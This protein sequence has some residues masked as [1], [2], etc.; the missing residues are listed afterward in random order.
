[1]FAGIQTDGNNKG[2]MA[3]FVVQKYREHFWYLW[4]MLFNPFLLVFL[5]LLLHHLWVIFKLRSTVY[6]SRIL[7]V[8]KMNSVCLLWMPTFFTRFLA[9]SFILLNPV[10]CKQSKFSLMFFW[11]SKCAIQV[12]V[13]EPQRS[14]DD[15]RVDFFSS[16]A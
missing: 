13:L 9:K 12:I 16:S 5:K 2:Q 10:A 15:F 1:M 8:N 11:L 6:V 4:K 14:F 3:I 7:H